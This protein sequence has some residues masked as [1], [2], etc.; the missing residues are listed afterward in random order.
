M[1]YLK[2]PFQS[3]F[4]LFLFVMITACK[5]TVDPAA[6]PNI[7][8]ILADDWSYPFASAYE[9]SP[10]HTPNLERLATM[11]MVFT[12]AFCATPSCTP[13]RSAILTGKYPHKLGEGVNL[14]GKLDTAETTYV[15]LLRQHGY[16]VAF[17]RKGW[18]PGKFEKMGYKENPAGHQQE[19]G[20]FLDSLDNKKPFCFWWGTN[21][22]H[23]PYT[24]GHGRKVGIDSTKL[25][26]P[27]FLPDLPDVR[28]DLADYY[29]E[30]KRVDREIGA[31][32]KKLED[33]G[34]LE[35]TM[36]VVTGDNGMPFPRAKANMYDYGTRVPLVI[37]FPK[38]FKRNRRSET[39]V[40]LIDL[41]PTFLEVADVPLP[42]DLDGISLVPVLKGKKKAHREEVFLERERHCMCRKNELGF[43]GYPMRAIRTKEYLY[44]LNLR[45]QRMPAGDPT[46]PGT[47]SEYGDVD[48]GP[49]KAYMM[50]HAMEDNVRTFFQIGFDKRP[51][52]ELYDVNADPF[53]VNNLAQYPKYQRLKK[54]LQLKLDIWMS[55]NEDPRWHG[56]GDEIDRYP[57]YDKAWITKWDIVFFDE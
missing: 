55:Q 45:P 8:F 23:R 46:I 31:L 3:L 49:T 5:P 9:D 13:S 24:R 48:G 28:G 26:V 35:N 30:I 25:S 11:G 33:K 22:P 50:D 44:I 19:F 20:A 41:M 54:N 37:S 57:T 14:V 39:F 29:A 7:L 32:L 52:E 15:K 51:R 34:L 47:P 40:N 53:N 21:D 43:P 27:K 56:G 4:F 12:H 17:E 42:K 18:A 38:K 2:K 36:I 16:A 1:N 6:K 10:I